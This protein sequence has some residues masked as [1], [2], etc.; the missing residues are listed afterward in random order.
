[1]TISEERADRIFQALGA[2]NAGLAALERAKTDRVESGLIA[3]KYEAL[4]KGKADKIDLL[5]LRDAIMKDLHETV[6]DLSERINGRFDATNS[7]IIDLRDRL[8]ALAVRLDGMADK[9]DAR[10][11]EIARLGDVLESLAKL[12]HERHEA[13]DADRRNRWR[14][15]RRILHVTAQ[16]SFQTFAGVVFLVILIQEGVTGLP[17]ALQLIKTAFGAP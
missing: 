7:Q 4:E 17:E 15:W 8:A 5:H 9:D 6:A 1:M 13:D 14:R 3:S 2:L 11:T 10:G 12:I 16:Y